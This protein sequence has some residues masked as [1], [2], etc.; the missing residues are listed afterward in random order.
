MMGWVQSCLAG[1]CALLA[2]CSDSDESARKPVEEK[3]DVSV[4][5]GGLCTSCDACEQ[6]LSVTG[7]AHVPG[8]V[9]YPDPPP[10]SGD[11][12][13]CWAKWGVHEQPVAD[14]NWVHNLE[15]GGVVYLYNCAEECEQQVKQLAEFVTGR[16]RALLTR[17]EALPT[18]FAVVSWGYRLLTDCFD[19]EVLEDFYTLHVG[20]GPESLSAGPPDDCP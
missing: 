1:L 15:H 12:N 6:Q 10:A 19:A 8:D 13:V 2:G 5:E 16:D 14:E 9:Q 7:S 3:P 20:N 17:Y 4:P 11:H 18:K